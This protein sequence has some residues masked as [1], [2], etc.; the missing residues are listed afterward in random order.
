MSDLRDARSLL[1]V[2][3][4][5]PERFAKAMASGADVVCVDWEDAVPMGERATARQATLIFL[6]DQ[7]P[8]H[9]YGLRINSVRQ[10]DGL[11]DLLSLIEARAKPAF[12]MLA[13]TESAE[14]IQLLAQHLPALPLIALVES[15]RGLS[16]AAA[17]AQAHPQ[18]QALMLGAADLAAEL[19]CDMAWGPL[20]HARCTLVAAA[21]CAGLAC[22]DV[23]WLDIADASGALQE[24]QLA[25]ALGFSGK[26]L[27]H[28]SQV[29]PVHAGLKPHEQALA[30]AQRIA[31]ACTTDTAAVMLDGRMVDR[32]VV[33][34]A[35]RLLR[36]A[37]LQ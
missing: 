7:M 17:I 3:G 20:L 5:R 4:N 16:Q 1:F 31:A 15:A 19:G 30:R 13:K 25:A 35:Q 9:R 34:A 22:L 32:P 11:R 10:T 23:P 37:A 33:L 8:G 28:P 29:Q 21:A 24:T 18:L 6:S 36:R 12:V 14:Q 26:A 27:I 2:P